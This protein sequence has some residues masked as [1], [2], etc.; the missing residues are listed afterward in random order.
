MFVL[1]ISN[2][3]NLFPF[4][5]AVPQEK[6]RKMKLFHTHTLTRFKKINIDKNNLYVT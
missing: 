3:I 1:A 4:F 5:C 2:N 6:V